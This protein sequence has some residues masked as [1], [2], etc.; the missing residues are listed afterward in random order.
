MLSLPAEEAKE[1]GGEAE[2]WQ[3]PGLQQ[4]QHRQVRQLEFELWTCKAKRLNAVS[5]AFKPRQSQDGGV[6][7]TQDWTQS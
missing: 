3:R 6:V 5:Q 1:E 4:Y 2:A 7:A